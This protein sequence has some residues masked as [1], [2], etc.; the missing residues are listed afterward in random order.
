MPEPDSAKPSNSGP[1]RD[2]DALLGED[3]GDAATDETGERAAEKPKL[4]LKPLITPLSPHLQAPHEKALKASSEDRPRMVIP[5]AVPIDPEP[6]LA[7]HEKPPPEEIDGAGELADPEGGQTAPAETAPDG[8]A[9][10]PGLD[11]AAP[12]DEMVE[13]VAHER[14]RTNWLLVAG[15]PVVPLLAIGWLV[16]YLFDPLGLKEEPALPPARTAVAK[17][18][19]P[20]REPIAENLAP[21]VLSLELE[22]T[23]LETYL[24]QLQQQR[25]RITRNPRGVIIAG[26][27]YQEGEAIHPGF[28]LFVQRVEGDQENGF[29]EIIGPEDQLYRVPVN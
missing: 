26:V 6:D 18:Q 13:L 19:T 12:E 11:E 15:L 22:E 7:P 27:F 29:V 17:P 9:T 25:V 5:H 23:S 14:K 3:P 24:A 10:T 4:K 28:G 16:N 20:Q 8:E 1:D 2:R 21:V